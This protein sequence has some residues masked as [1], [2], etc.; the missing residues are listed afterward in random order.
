MLTP[1]QQHFIKKANS[2]LLNKYGWVSFYFKIFCP[3]KGRPKSSLRQYQPATPF[4]NK[5]RHWPWGEEI[6]L[7]FPQHVMSFA[8]FGMKASNACIIRTTNVLS[9]FLD[10]LCQ[11]PLPRSIW[12][13]LGAWA[14]RCHDQFAVSVQKLLFAKKTNS[15]W[16]PHW[17][18]SCVLSKNYS[19]LRDASHSRTSH[20]KSKQIQFK[21][22]TL[23]AR[24]LHMRPRRCWISMFY[25]N[26]RL[27]CGA[28]V[29]FVLCSDLPI[30]QARL[31]T[32]NPRH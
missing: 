20:K 26:A 10:S 31:W 18:L 9:Q 28:N 3:D 25:Q 14:E 27:F 15:L 22:S 1:V 11:H 4:Q 29:A 23:A 2:E 12:V 5:S 13:F 21:Y 8:F 6:I 32:L 7:A 24:S 17:N 16:L 30:Q 19:N